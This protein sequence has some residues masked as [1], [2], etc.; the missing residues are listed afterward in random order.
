ME[1]KEFKKAELEVIS[2][3]MDDIITASGFT[4]TGPTMEVEEG[5]L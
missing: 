1:K 4:V 3:E 5:E 2:F